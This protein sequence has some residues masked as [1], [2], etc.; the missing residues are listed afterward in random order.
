MPV[1]G[2]AHFRAAVFIQTRFTARVERGCFYLI[3]IVVVSKNFAGPAIL[4]ESRFAGRIEEP[5][6]PS[7]LP[8]RHG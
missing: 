3:A 7:D 8:W 1:I 4:G 2:D 5:V 6:L